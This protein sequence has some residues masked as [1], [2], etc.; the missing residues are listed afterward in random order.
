M[1]YQA[2]YRKFRP[3][4]FEDVSGQDAI[5]TTLK[6]QIKTNR[7]GHAYLFC[8]TRGTGKTTVAKIFARAVNCENPSEDGSPCLKCEICKG[9][10]DGTLMN[11]IEIDAASNNG[12]ENVRTIIDEISY[13]PS[14]GKYKVYIID[15]VH[16]LSAGAFNALLKT[17]EEPPEYVIFILATTEVAKIPVTILSRCQRYDFRRMSIDTMVNRMRTLV[18]KEQADVEDRALKFIARTADGSMRDALS[19]LDQ[20]LAFNY[21]KEL[22]YDRALDV[23]GAVDSS[24]Y[25]DFMDKILKE[26]LSGAINILD[27]NIMRGRE[28]GSFVNDLIWHMRNMLLLSTSDDSNADIADVLGVSTDTL[29]QIRISAKKT[30][31]ETLMRFIRIFSELSGQIRFS[32]QKRV[33]TEIAIVKLMRP[34]MEDDISSVKQRLAQVERKM[35]KLETD[36]VKVSKSAPVA[37][38]DRPKRPLPDALPEDVSLAAANWGKIV[39]NSDPSIKNFLDLSEPST[40]GKNLIIKCMDDIQADTLKQPENID[41][42]NDVLER[43]LGKKVVFS[44]YGTKSTERESGGLFDISEYINAEIE[45][46]EGG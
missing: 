1:A 30:D 36:G 41:L 29:E 35:N 18:D 12:V 31:P 9:L 32:Q 20:C 44:I 21:G 10:K 17:L 46:D 11:V 7:I 5:V 33:L 15:E 40:D 13:S 3:E 22:T 6:N 45:T 2:L 38:I 28:L 23:L 27:E 16:M 37:E 8:G 26:D 24:V 39:R 14:R 34:Q 19:L 42:I 25:V 43:E 4:V